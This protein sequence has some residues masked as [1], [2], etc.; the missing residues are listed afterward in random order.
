M[1]I[2]I[3]VDKRQPVAYNVLQHSI[4]RRAKTPVTIT[5]LNIDWMPMKRR[6]LT[7]FTF[8]RYLV[9]YL[10]NYEGEALFL[11]GDMLARAD[12]NELK[13]LIDPEVSVS[14]VKNPLRFEWPSLMYFNNA[15]CKNLTPEYIE[16][17]KPQALEWAE[18]IGELP[19]E[20]N[21]LVG[22]D[23]L[24]P[25]AKIV[26]FT[27]GLPCWKET[28]GCEFSDEWREEANHTMGTVSWSDLMGNSVHQPFNK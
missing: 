28:E 11:D 12:I 6:G 26:H 18:A 27:R 23:N 2:F 9:P 17:Q 4:I 1:R 19:E 5:P 25:D 14:V 7:D 24:N 22:Y 3:G 13:D 20:W 16:T 10:C 8:T 15:K 21:H